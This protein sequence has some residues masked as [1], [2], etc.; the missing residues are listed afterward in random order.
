MPEPGRLVMVCGQPLVA[1]RCTVAGCALVAMTNLTSVTLL[2]QIAVAVVTSD[3]HA[4]A[5]LSSKYTVRTEAAGVA[6]D[7]A[8]AAMLTG[9]AASGRSTQAPTMSA[10]AVGRLGICGPSGRGIGAIRPVAPL[11]VDRVSGFEVY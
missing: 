10:R 4:P 1:I 6:V 11:T 8:D 2:F 3:F 7:G 9:A 5:R